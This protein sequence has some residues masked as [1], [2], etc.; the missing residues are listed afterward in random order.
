MMRWRRTVAETT[1]LIEVSQGRAPADLYVANGRVL[2]V[3]SG[4][5]I[6]ANVAVAGERIAYVGGS[7]RMVAPSTEVIDADGHYLLPG[8]L[9]P[10]THL[11]IGYNPTTLSME[12]LKRG[13]TA[14]FSSH[15]P[16]Q[17]ALSV[18]DFRAAVQEVFEHPARISIGLEAETG[19]F[20]GDGPLTPEE[21]AT[22]AFDL[23]GV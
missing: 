2:N 5:V 13:T 7:D 14:L 23:E 20:L 16:F 12:M 10:H 11:D 19:F 9:E 17:D 4:E 22:Q 15:C 8:F 18:P 6:S 3:F 1:H 21:M